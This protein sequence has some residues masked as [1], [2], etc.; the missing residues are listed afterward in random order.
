MRVILELTIPGIPVAKGRVRVTRKGVAYTPKK[1]ATTESYIRLMASRAYQEP[2]PSTKPITIYILGFF[3]PEKNLSKAKAWDKVKN[4][5]PV[6][7][8]PDLDNIAKLIMDSLN[9]IVWED[10]S[11]VYS[12]ILSKR[13]NSEGYTRV[14]VAED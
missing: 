13:Y 14:I 4:L 10:D 9:K 3:P 7:K 5:L 2:A 1:T 11:Q 6:T 12:M 8:R